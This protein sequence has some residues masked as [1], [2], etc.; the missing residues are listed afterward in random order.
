MVRPRTKCAGGVGRC[1]RQQAAR[2]EREQ[3]KTI[4][5]TGASGSLGRAAVAALVA[6][7]CSVRAASR[8]PRPAADPAVQAVHFD[9]TDPGT[10]QSALEGADG[11]MLI[12]PPLDVDSAAKLNP[13]I[14]RARALGIGQIVLNSALGV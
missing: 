1:A 12:A 7:G 6:R 3:M 13:V 5:V 9:Y 11:V 8:H 4:L 14:D 2:K 10:H